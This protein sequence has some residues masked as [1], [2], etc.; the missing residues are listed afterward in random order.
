MILVIH[1]FS[2]PKFSIF[3]NNIVH[4]ILKLMMVIRIKKHLQTE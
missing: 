1:L 4:N 2:Q 3:E